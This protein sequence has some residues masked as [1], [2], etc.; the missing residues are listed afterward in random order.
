MLLGR[1]I[2][3]AEYSSNPSLVLRVIR[4]EMRESYDIG[5]EHRHVPAVFQ[6]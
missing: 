4:C 6:R 5:K 1:R 2:E 3:G